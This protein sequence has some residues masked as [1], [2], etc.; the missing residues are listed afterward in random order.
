MLAKVRRW[1]NGLALRVLKEDLETT[2]IAEGDTV[3]I[4]IIGRP[5][6]GLDLGSL[7]TFEDDDPRASQRHD[8]YLYG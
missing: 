3:Q 4:E 8:R 6:R 2:G 1:G 7:P 5:G